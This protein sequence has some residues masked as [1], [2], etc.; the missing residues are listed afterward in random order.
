VDGRCNKLIAQELIL[1]HLIC[2]PFWGASP[3]GGLRLR[4]IKSTTTPNPRTKNI[5]SHYLQ[6]TTEMAL[7]TRIKRL[8]NHNVET[9]KSQPL[10]ELSGALGDLG[11]LLPLMIALTLTHSISLPSTLV[12]AGL[13]NILTGVVFGLP[14]PVQPMKAIAA[15]AIARNFTIR[16]NAAAGLTVSTIVLLLSLSGLLNWFSRVI[17]IPVVK[18]I[19]VGAGLSLIL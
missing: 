16:E 7:A 11:T 3:R 18:G 19:Q 10:A 5:H 14:L 9:L 17:P 4:K 13:A 15:V 6:I 2:P 1:I 8:H 12:F